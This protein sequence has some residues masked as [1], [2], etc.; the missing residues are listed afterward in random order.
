[1]SRVAR[2]SDFAPLSFRD[3]AGAFGNNVVV[4]RKTW[5]GKA[6]KPKQF[7]PGPS[8][9]S[10]TMGKTDFLNPGSP[11]HIQFALALC[12]SAVCR[13][14]KVEIVR[15]FGLS[16]NLYWGKAGH[17]K[18]ATT[19][20]KLASANRP[21][22]LLTSNLG[23]IAASGASIVA[24]QLPVGLSMQFVALADVAD[25]VWRTRRPKAR[26]IISLTWIGRAALAAIKLLC[27]IYGPTQ[28]T[29][30]PKPAPPLTGTLP[31]RLSMVIAR[32]CS[33]GS[34]SLMN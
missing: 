25:L 33:P 28:R 16:R 17:Y 1:M 7:E 29:T 14:L 31:A 18:L 26:Q 15:N 13:V 12:L 4:G 24:G 9:D 5:Q 8:P 22:R 2:H 34:D 27:W 23:A 10:P 3:K 32:R 30:H 21:E 19:A 11:G 6:A 20:C